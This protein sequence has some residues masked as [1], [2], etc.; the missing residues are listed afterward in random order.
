MSSIPIGS[1]AKTEAKSADGNVEGPR[2]VAPLTHLSRFTL[3]SNRVERAARS[4]L[5]GR[6]VALPRAITRR[7]GCPAHK[8]PNVKGRPFSARE[9]A[10][11]LEEAGLVTKP[12]ELAGGARDDFH[13]PGQAKKVAGTMVHPHFGRPA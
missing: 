6:Q 8:L 12:P 3:H 9:A 4:R 1:L 2:H 11:E 7:D 13:P 10:K 5:H